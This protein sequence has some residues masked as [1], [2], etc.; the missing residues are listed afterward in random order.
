MVSYSFGL[1][2][3]VLAL[4]SPLFHSGADE[5]YYLLFSL[6]VVLG[7][8]IF[9]LPRKFPG[10]LRLPLGAFI[11]FSAVALLTLIPVPFFL[12]GVLSPGLHDILLRLH[13]T[14]AHALS[15]DPWWTVRTLAVYASAAGLVLIAHQITGDEHR[16]LPV[17]MNILFWWGVVIAGYTTVSALFVQPA[18]W[19][20]V[21][22]AQP[23]NFGPFAN[24]NIFA[25]YCAL[26]IP[27]GV[28]LFVHA[29][30][31]ERFFTGLPLLYLPGL[32][33][34]GLALYSSH[35]LGGM[36]AL[37]AA[38]VVYAFPKKP[39]WTAAAAALLLAG[40]AAV[41]PVIK[42][43]AVESFSQRMHASG[44][45]LS[46][47]AHS[48]LTGTGLGTVEIS[49]PLKQKPLMHYVVDKIHDDYLELLA[50]GG[51]L[52]LVFFAGILVWALR[53]L[54]FLK[55]GYTL[56]SGLVVGLLAVAF[57]SFVDFPLQNF[58]VLGMFCI[59]LGIVSSFHPMPPLAPLRSLKPAFLG[60]LIVGGGVWVCCY[61]GL[62][63]TAKGDAS[64]WQV[65]RS[66]PIIRHNPAMGEYMARHHALYAPI[67]G[68]LSRAYEARDQQ[69]KAVEA[70]EKAC[71]LQPQNASLHLTAAKQY[72]LD[73]RD[74]QIA[75]ALI[76]TYSLSPMLGIETIPLSLKEREG[77][78]FAALPRAY[79]NYGA[80]STEFYV[81]AYL[82]LNWWRSD[83]LIEMLRQAHGNLPHSTD[84][85]NDLAEELLL[86]GNVREG[87]EVAQRMDAESPNAKSCLLIARA[88]AALHREKEIRDWLYR[89]LGLAQGRNA[90]LV[91]EGARMLKSF[92][93][94]ESLR[95]LQ[96][97]FHS[98]PDVY[99]AYILGTEYLERGELW[100][101]AEWYEKAYRVN[102]R[103]SAAYH[104]QIQVYTRLGERVR[105]AQ[106][107]EVAQ[108]Y[109][110]SEKWGTE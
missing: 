19:M 84:L 90:W 26:L 60:L 88:D 97:G 39:L 17:F 52:G 69:A 92:A 64:V 50:T 41:Q 3:L 49:A 9:L 6:G 32:A 58:S 76:L 10:A 57:H 31:H 108:K 45:A 16:R 89:G 107:A 28:A 102:P 106:T 80:F 11:G 66:L 79:H 105:A 8:L 44:I 73:G 65:S 27:V 29:L 47:W 72:Y 42:P 43:R 15:W 74:D 81:N 35:S 7:A 91:L 101:A 100:T 78:L 98:D 20:S 83:R 36:L 37:L 109:C 85:A 12:L 94:D 23:W 82:L 104:A 56:R 61:A 63:R 110:P 68:E 38:A 70:I 5:K 99:T 53:G 95:L 1:A 93:P 24:A 54:V 25:S 22:E 87:L 4:L 96:T 33:L 75:P 103:F 51:I 18:A 48:P 40:L 2:A 46:L 67:W 30:R 14:S 77:V 13:L 86:A 71:L 55:P 21:G 59:V 34:L 62:V